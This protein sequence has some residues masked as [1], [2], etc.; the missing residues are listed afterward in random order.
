MSPPPSSWECLLR[1]QR[2]GV[3]TETW[4]LSANSNFLYSNTLQSRFDRKFSSTNY[5]TF[6]VGHWSSSKF[7]ETWSS[8]KVWDS[9]VLNFSA[10]MGQNCLSNRKS[11]TIYPTTVPKVINFPQYNMKCSV[12]NVILRG[13]FYVVSRFPLHFKWY[14]ADIWISFLTGVSPEI[15][16]FE[17]L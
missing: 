14:I 11:Q 2:R 3:F 9:R 1:L 8:E 16:G 4:N 17:N 10:L 7:D 12:E 6:G 15:I 5:K 13:I